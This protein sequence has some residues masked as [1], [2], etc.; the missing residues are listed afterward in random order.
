MGTGEFV[1][2]EEY[3]FWPYDLF[4]YVRGAAVSGK[5]N[6]NNGDPIVFAEG[7]G[8]MRASHLCDFFEGFTQYDKIKILE[9]EYQRKQRELL[10][11]YKQKLVDTAPF[12]SEFPA[13]KDK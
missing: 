10:S 6:L 7:F 1:M 5:G 13:F 3:A 8:A 11:E 2:T 12:L 9:L 4:R